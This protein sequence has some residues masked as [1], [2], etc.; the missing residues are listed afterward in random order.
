MGAFMQ[1][2]VSG[3]ISQK[4]RKTGKKKVVPSNTRTSIDY[5]EGY[6]RA[7]WKWAVV[8]IGT[9]ILV[10]CGTLLALHFGLKNHNNLHVDPHAFQ[11]DEHHVPGEAL[12]RVLIEIVEHEMGGFSGWRPNDFILWGPMIWADNNSWRQIGIIDAVRETARVFKDSLTKVS[13]D[14]IDS[15]LGEADY[16]F[17]NDESKLWFP[18]AEN[19]FSRGCEALEEYL[20]GLQTDPPRSRPL[21]GRNWDLI[22]LLEA[23]TDLLGDAQGLLYRTKEPDG[24]KIRAWKNDNYFYRS[25]GYAHV[26]NLVLQAVTVEYGDGLNPSVKLL[27]HEVIEALEHAAHLKPLIVLDGSPS[28]LLANHRR[29]LHTYISEGRDKMFSIGAELEK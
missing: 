5:G 7:F 26:M 12:A 20:E 15:N 10:Y 17:R 2:K 23:Y 14:A 28:S 19:R 8:I 1:K 9:L 18:S 3:G 29:N 24:G 11:K 27:F 25:Q 13:S 4:G 22:K 6:T 16:A 21:V